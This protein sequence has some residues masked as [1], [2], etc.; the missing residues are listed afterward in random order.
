MIYVKT[1]ARYFH[2]FY[3]TASNWN[4]ALAFFM[5]YHD[6][7]GAS[8]Y[9]IRRSFA[10]VSLANLTITDADITRSSP[11]EAVSFYML[12][13]LLNALRTFSRA[14]D[15]VDLGCGKGRVLA[16]AAH[17]GFNR[18]VGIDFAK[19]LCEEAE[20]NMQ[21]VQRHF[22]GVGYEIIHS[23]VLCYHIQPTD[24]VFFLFNPFDAGTLVQFLQMLHQS[25]LLYPRDTWFIYASPQHIEVLIRAGYKQVF[26]T[27]MMNL[28]GKIFFK[29]A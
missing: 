5:L 7:R 14:T 13:K 2:F 15:I 12:E 6:I 18:I 24:S 27:Q 21:K 25:L 17:H 10:P 3:Y 16:V 23:N 11:Y 8:R 20:R 29:Q 4:I 28:K 22:P 19:E 1:I 26:E 9:G